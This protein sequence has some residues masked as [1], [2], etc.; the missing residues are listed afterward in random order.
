MAY[1]TVNDCRLKLRTDFEG[2]YKLPDEQPDLN[3]DMA[4][5]EAVVNGYV[6]KRYQ[7]P[8]TDAQAMTLVKAYT[9]DLFSELAYQRGAGSEIPPKIRDRADVARRQ[10]TDISLGKL[11]LAG[12]V[13]I[14][15]P[16]G[17]AIA[18]VNGPAPSFTQ[19]QMGG[20]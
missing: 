17:A 20:F 5:A 9:L 8:V 13:A 2:L 14:N 10:L 18:V 4:D 19:D 11:T 6:G 12:A 1:I 16:G 7:V 15:P 3:R